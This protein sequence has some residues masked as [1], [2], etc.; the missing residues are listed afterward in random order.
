MV[1]HNGLIDLVFLYHN[2]WCALPDK[3]GTFV[4]DL[5]EMFPGGVYDTKYIADFVSRTQASYLEFVFR[6]EQRSNQDKAAAG[7]PHVKVAW[8]E[9]EDKEVCFNYAHHGH[10]PDGNSCPKSHSIDGILKAK[11]LEQEK[12]RKKRKVDT[13]LEDATAKVSKVEEEAGSE[14]TEEASAAKGNVLKMQRL[15][16]QRLRRK[17]S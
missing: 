17:Q 13:E 11:N 4:A 8:E 5:A 3:L 16:C 7:R 1:L 9:E 6:K 14:L 15:K 2:F 12:K 10:C